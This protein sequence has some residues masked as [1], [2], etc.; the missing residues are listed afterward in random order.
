M[1][2]CGKRK[3]CPAT[4]RPARCTRTKGHLGPCDCCGHDTRAAKRQT[5]AFGNA[6][7]NLATRAP[8]CGA[9]PR[10]GACRSCGCREDRGHRGKHICA[11][12][13]KRWR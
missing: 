2:A 6:L 9:R 5:R 12:C 4:G 10:S 13:G 1:L 11:N 7:T 8:L 3:T